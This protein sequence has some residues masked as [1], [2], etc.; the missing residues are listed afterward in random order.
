MQALWGRRQLV[1][2]GRRQP[3]FNICSMGSM[4]DSVGKKSLWQIVRRSE[5]ERWLTFAGSPFL[6]FWAG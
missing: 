3:V 5:V 4:G 6:L 1:Q 2:A